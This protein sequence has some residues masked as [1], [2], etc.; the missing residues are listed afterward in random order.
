MTLRKNA[1]IDLPGAKPQ[2]YLV[3]G[4]AGYVGSHLVAKL[5]EQ[6]AEVV[7][8]DD[9]KQGHRAA[10]PAGVQLV[11]GN[12]ANPD[13]IS[14]AFGLGPFAAIFHFAA[15]SLV[16]DSMANPFRYFEE[17]CLSS[18][19]LIEAACRY[20][21]KRLVFSST[22]NLFGTPLQM[23]ITETELVA[24]GSPYGESKFIVERILVWA[25]RIHGL[26]SACLRYFNAAGA[27]PSGR[28]GEHHNPET[29]LIP[30]LIDAALRRR[31]PVT[32]FGT[33]YPTPDG[34]CIRDYVHV[35]DLASA[36]L[37][38]LPLL[39]TRSVAYNVGSGT[40]YSVLETIAAV[41][42]VTGLDVPMH[43]GARR[44]GDPAVLV[45]D[46]TAL[47]HDT[48]WTPEHSE[49]TAIVATAYRWRAAHPAGYGKPAQA[50]AHHGMEQKPA[51]APA[52]TAPTHPPTT[53]SLH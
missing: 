24:P 10:V 37:A 49:L 20:G 4:G 44:A 48:G 26:H 3:T 27:D 9:L 17:N 29:H 16:S 15:L 36:H 23:P 21:V 32:V 14:E 25:E 1:A 51:F 39:E 35:C 53:S 34:T 38:V 12:L 50:A 18:L 2:R 41:R 30:L 5:L 52:D 47:R 13:V 6:G 22:A 46:A 33:D 31:P 43:L 45:A 28:L 42:A 11:V 8:L 40:G 19:R 7:V